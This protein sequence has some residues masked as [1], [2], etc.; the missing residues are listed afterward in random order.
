MH[1]TG[2]I[3]LGVG[4]DNARLRGGMANA[5]SEA[6]VPGLSIGTFYEG[7]LTVGCKHISAR[8]QVVLSPPSTIISHNAPA[9]VIVVLS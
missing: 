1:K 4:G 2:A 6:G 7:V 3:I 5:R 9:P 8:V